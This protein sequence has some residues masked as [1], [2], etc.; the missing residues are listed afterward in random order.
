MGKQSH[1]MGPGCDPFVYPAGPHQRHQRHAA[2]LRPGGAKSAG[3]SHLCGQ[4]RHS[5]NAPGCWGRAGKFSGRSWPITG[6]TIPSTVTKPP[7]H[8]RAFWTPPLRWNRRRGGVWPL[9][10]TSRTMPPRP[11]GKPISPPSTWPWERGPGPAPE[12]CPGHGAAGPGAVGDP[13]GAGHLY[14]RFRS[15]R[16]NCPGCRDSLHLRLLGLPE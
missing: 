11:S 7:V 12:A 1:F 13:P 2:G 9:S 5:A 10:P 4:R 14:R 15:R 16:G 3:G 8:M 6:H